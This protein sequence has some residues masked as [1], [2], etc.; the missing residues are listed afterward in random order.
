MHIYVQMDTG[1]HIDGGRWTYR[2]REIDRHTDGEMTEICLSICTDRDEKIDSNTYAEVESYT[3]RES[4]AKISYRLE[5]C[6][7]ESKRRNS[8][9]QVSFPS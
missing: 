1:G 6:N 9:K 2:L 7:G 4:H 5:D 8:L 3:N